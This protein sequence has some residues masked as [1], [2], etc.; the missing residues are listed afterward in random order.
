M[1]FD[2]VIINGTTYWYSGT[3]GVPV[4]QP[5]GPGFTTGECGIQFQ[6]D[7]WSSGPGGNITY[8]IDQA[9]FTAAPATGQSTSIT[10]SVVF[11]EN[12]STQGNNNNSAYIYDSSSFSDFLIVNGEGTGQVTS[13]DNQPT[14]PSPVFN[15]IVIV[16][17][18]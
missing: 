18:E 12:L 4:Q 14:I 6:V 15:P 3:P 17:E 1:Y 13:V 8:Y 5:S 2:Y 10:D 7:L 9:S 16:G 11:G